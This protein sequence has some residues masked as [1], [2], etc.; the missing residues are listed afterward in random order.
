MNTNVPSV[1][2][3]KGTERALEAAPF[4]PKSTGDVGDI[5]GKLAVR[6]T[7]VTLQEKTTRLTLKTYKNIQAN[8]KI[9]V[10]Y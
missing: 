9:F 7:T 10:V 6:A 3:K 1:S 8:V 5:V 2:M 4:L